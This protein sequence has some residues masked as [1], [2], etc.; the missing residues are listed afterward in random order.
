MNL[1]T[2]VQLAFGLFGISLQE[3]DL[4]IKIK[5]EDL[6]RVGIWLILDEEL[7]EVLHSLA[8]ADS[9][10]VYLVCPNPLGVMGDTGK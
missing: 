2:A 10:A 3:V 9:F 1:G 7:Q 4:Q 5:E 8:L 6:L